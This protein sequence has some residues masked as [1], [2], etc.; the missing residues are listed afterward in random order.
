MR[1][2]ILRTPGVGLPALRRI[3]FGRMAA[4]SA[5][6]VRVRNRGDGTVHH[7]SVCKLRGR[8][9]G[10]FD[11]HMRIH[12]AGQ[13]ITDRRLRNFVYSGDNATGYL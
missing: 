10:A 9:H 5:A 11:V 13:D 7:C 8:E 2:A 12:K 1:A 6:S 3:G 4:S